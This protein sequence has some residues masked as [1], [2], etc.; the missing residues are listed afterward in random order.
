MSPNKSVAQRLGRVL[1][2]VTRQSGRLTE[3]PAYGSFLLGRVSESPRRRRIRVQVIL[4]ILVAGVNFIGIAVAILLVTVAIPEPSVFEDAPWWV[5]FVAVPVYIALAV[6]VGTY[7]LTSRTV[8]ALRWA[9]EGRK[10]SRLDERNT[11]LAPWRLATVDLILWGVG[12]ALLTTLYGMANTMFVPRFLFVVG[13]SG[14]MV[15]TFSY[16]L[17]E[18]ALRP[19][20]AVALEAGRPP[21]R[22]MAGIMGRTMMVWLV[23]SGVPVVG[24]ALIAFFQ[25]LWRNLTEDQ[26]AVGVFIVAAAAFV[27]GGIL[28]WIVSWLT[29]T[30]RAGCTCGAQARR[31]G[32]LAGRPG[33]VRRHRTRG[34]AA[35]FQLNGRRPA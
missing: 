11:F 15:A 18:F 5:T 27:F 9:T 13:I 21:R 8:N 6:A 10:P 34:A 12:T 22:L 7:W 28:M 24:I 30:T 2:A 31:A 17:T 4:T 32:R 16:L 1:E 23:G 19:F 33:G 29:A 14:V 26:F 20:A 3:T 35:W 25:I